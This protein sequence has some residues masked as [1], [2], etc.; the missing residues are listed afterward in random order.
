MLP[1]NNRFFRNVSRLYG[2][3]SYDKGPKTDSEEVAVASQRYYPIIMLERLK[4][5]TTT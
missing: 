3:E 2:V 4:R 5:T 1:P